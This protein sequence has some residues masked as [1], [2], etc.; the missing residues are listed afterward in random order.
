MPSAWSAC[1]TVC[2]KAF[3]SRSLRCLSDANASVPLSACESSASAGPK[4]AVQQYCNADRPCNATVNGAIQLESGGLI[5]VDLEAGGVDA[6]VFTIPTGAQ[7]VDILFIAMAGD[8]S[9]ASHLTDSMWSGANATSSVYSD[10]NVPY[11]ETGYFTETDPGFRAGATIAVTTHCAGDTD[12]TYE[13]VATA[14][15]VPTSSASKTVA[16]DGTTPA[17]VRYYPAPTA[18]GIVVHVSPAPNNDYAEDVVVA[19]ARADLVGKPAVAQT[20]PKAVDAPWVADAGS[21]GADEE[22]M[23]VGGDFFMGGYNLAV[24][25]ASCAEWQTGVGIVVTVTDVLSLESGA[26]TEGVLP[27]GGQAFF[28]LPFAASAGAAKTELL[29]I[30]GDTDVF[31][32][33]DPFRVSEDLDCNYPCLD[34]S[35]AIAPKEIVVLQKIEQLYWGGGIF[36]VVRACGWWKV[37][38][39][40]RPRKGT[41]TVLTAQGWRWWLSR[42]RSLASTT[43]T[44]FEWGRLQ[45]ASWAKENPQAVSCRHC[46]T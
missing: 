35:I 39:C 15:F 32:G 22:I 31:V 20:W 3:Q 12:C 28:W 43:A 8:A 27:K 44:A 42:S 18:V 40:P 6:L 17:F 21:F 34:Y 16:V 24:K 33:F 7:A 13:L 19:M 10:F 1:S 9:M 2:G 23:L 11:E 30:T 41:E 26:S 5:R 37:V 46:S 38:A 45:E 14:Y 36:V 25:C 4:P 29:T